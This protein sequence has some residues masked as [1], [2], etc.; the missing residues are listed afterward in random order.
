MS[1]PEDHRFHPVIEVALLTLICCSVGLFILE[2]DIIKTVH[3]REGDPFWLWFERLAAGIF[4]VEFILRWRAIG[5]AYPLSGMGLIDAVAILPFWAGFLV[6]TSWLGI[7][8]TLRI[9]RLLK[10]YRYSRSVQVFLRALNYSRHYLSGMMLMVLILML[11]SAVGI[12]VLEKDTQPEHFGSLSNSIWWTTV[13]LMTVGY[14]DAA[15]VTLQGKV[16]AQ[17][18]MIIG[19]AL[20]AA[21]IGIVGSSVYN[22][23]QRLEKEHE[24]SPTVDGK[25]DADDGPSV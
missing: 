13:T 19:V 24:I 9:L 23:M 20:T 21:F 2:V 5:R 25:A 15:P 7:V 14:G 12:H 6:P 17:L 1:K 16:F 10:L 8:R 11:L 22:Q 18:V 4:T 3:S